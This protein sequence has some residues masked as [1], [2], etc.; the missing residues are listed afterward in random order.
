MSKRK[1]YVVWK[2]R[3]TGI[4]TSWVE[5]EAQVKGFVDAKFKAFDSR[6]EAEAAF[7]SQYEA[8]RGRPAT[9]GQWKSADPPPALP[10]LCVDAACSGAPGPLEYQGVRLPTGERLFHAGPFPDG[11]NNVGEFLA[12]VHA[13]AWLSKHGLTLPVYSDSENAIAWV[14]N[15][16][17]NTKLQHTP[18][19]AQLFALIHSAENWLAENELRDDAVLK[20]DTQAW[21]ENP[22]DF[23]RK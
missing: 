22:A 18:S 2:G 16:R 11:T 9:L 1:F 5:C 21:G 12:L 10:C 14:F 6:A 13:L 19:N 17:A 7:Q 3:K 20:W 4:F 23:G 15:G 8:Y